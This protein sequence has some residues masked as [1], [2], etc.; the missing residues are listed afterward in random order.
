MKYFFLQKQ[1]SFY[2][3]FNLTASHWKVDENVKKKEYKL[4][5]GALKTNLAKNY[6]NGKVIYWKPLS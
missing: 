1:V 3:P 5:K 6:R 2:E 4:F